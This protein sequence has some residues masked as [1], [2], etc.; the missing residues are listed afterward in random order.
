M[1]QKFR[2]TLRVNVGFFTQTIV[3]LFIKN[4]RTNTVKIYKSESSS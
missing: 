2:Y 4:L 1:V 3:T